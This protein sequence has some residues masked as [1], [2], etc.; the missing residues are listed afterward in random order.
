MNFSGGWY[1]PSIWSF[2]KGVFVNTM[3]YKNQ[4]AYPFVEV[5]KGFFVTDKVRMLATSG[6]FLIK[7]LPEYTIITLPFQVFKF[8]LLRHFESN[9]MKSLAIID[10]IISR[11]SRFN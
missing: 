8:K 9:F 6:N 3:H 5:G 2:T 7:K 11:Y 10:S 4:F 1:G